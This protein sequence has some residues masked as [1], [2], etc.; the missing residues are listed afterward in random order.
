L[1][2]V[3][4]RSDRKSLDEPL[5]LYCI[6]RRI[7]DKRFWF[8]WDQIQRRASDIGRWI[9]Q[10]TIRGK[11]AMIVNQQNTWGKSAAF[12]AIWHS[13][14]HAEA[15]LREAKWLCPDRRVKLQFGEP[16]GHF[17]RNP[18]YDRLTLQVFCG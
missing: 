6:L 17:A 2:S 8:F 4:T 7:P 10:R 12:S 1:A 3:P 11:N 5:C 15:A 14:S 9:G 13:L 18:R 16:V